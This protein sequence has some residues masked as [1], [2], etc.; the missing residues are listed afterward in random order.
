[1]SHTSSRSSRLARLAAGVAV[2]A[3]ATGA[4]LLGAAPAYAQAAS[5][6]ASTSGGTLNVVGTSFGNIITADG[7]NGVISLSNLTGAI[8]A[9]GP[10]CK[11]L[12]AVV[13][14]TGVSSISFSGLGGDDKFDNRTSTPS[15]QRGGSGNDILRGGSGNDRLIGGLGSDSAAGGN[16]TDTCVA[17]GESSCEL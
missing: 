1:M 6:T 7:G 12:G 17:E 2:T 10:G 9:N 3:A 16:G 13:R 15:S 4:T 14:C 8:T 5:T 11:Q